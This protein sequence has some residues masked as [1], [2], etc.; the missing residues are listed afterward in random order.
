MVE[1]WILAALRHRQF[2]SLAELNVTISTLLIKLYDHAFRKLPG[3]SQEHFEQMDL[4]ALQLLAGPSPL[5]IFVSRRTGI[6]IAWVS[7]P[8]SSTYI[9]TSG[10]RRI[11][12]HVSIPSSCPVIRSLRLSVCILPC[13]DEGDPLT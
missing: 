12:L 13:V 2:F 3:C 4:P 11:T 10:S 6:A 1:R 8:N 5:K 7:V 9:S